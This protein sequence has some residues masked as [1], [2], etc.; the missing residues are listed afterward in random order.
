MN[1]ERVR[2]IP[3]EV[4]ARHLENVAE[5]GCVVD[6]DVGNARRVVLEKRELEIPERV[7]CLEAAGG[8]QPLR[9]LVQ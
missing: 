2:R 3:G 7:E 9:R 4:I 8:K 5:P 1:V 6:I